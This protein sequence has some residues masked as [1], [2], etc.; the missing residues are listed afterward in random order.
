MVRIFYKY[1]DCN[2]IYTALSKPL[3]VCICYWEKI[4]I[5]PGVYWLFQL[6]SSILRPGLRILAEKVRWVWFWRWDFSVKL[7]PCYVVLI[8]TLRRTLR[9]FFLGMVKT[10]F[11]S[12]GSYFPREHR[13]GKPGKPGKPE[14][15]W[16]DEQPA[17]HINSTLWCYLPVQFE[18]RYDWCDTCAVSC[19]QFDRFN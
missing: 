7:E 6:D 10:A 9:L 15:L 11:Y 13:K 2:S 3:V 5:F 16:K 1:S 8:P 18:E 14:S 19:Y 12:P 17:K 4:G